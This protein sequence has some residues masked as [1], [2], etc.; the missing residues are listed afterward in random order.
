M[1]LAI[2]DTETGGKYD[3]P[4]SENFISELAIVVY[5]TKLQSIVQVFSK[6]FKNEQ[7]IS[8]ESTE[9]H[10]ITN[11]MVS[12]YGVPISTGSP[13]LGEVCSILDSCDYVVAHNALGFDKIVMSNY[14]AKFG[15]E[16]PAVTWIDST[17][18]V[19][20]PSSVKYKNLT[21]LSGYYGVVNQFQHRALFDCFT[22]LKILLN[23]DLDVVIQNA[24]E[25]LFL[26]RAD[27]TFNQ[28]DLAKS[29]GFMWEK[30]N[31]YYEFK[32]WIKIM[33]ES[34]YSTSSFPFNVTVLKHL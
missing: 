3:S 12:D 19:P 23:F 2:L 8:P 22:L 14:L 24:N 1:I 16:M 13:V 11:S 17:I 10:G 32:S 28:K 25:P 4:L 6:L 31:S 20:Y 26:V 21:Y 9:T 33:T 5:D 29:E 15:F 18:H 30:C 7:L 27:V 34:Q